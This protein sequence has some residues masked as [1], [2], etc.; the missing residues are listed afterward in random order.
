MLLCK[1][2]YT[3]SGNTSRSHFR[4]LTFIASK[5]YFES[6]EVSLGELCTTKLLKIRHQN[7]EAE[8]P[9]FRIIILIIR[10]E[11]GLDRPV[12]A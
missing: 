8:D 1:S 10:H 9:T 4:G 3:H 11:L 7:R 6:G 2:L 12:L 5:V